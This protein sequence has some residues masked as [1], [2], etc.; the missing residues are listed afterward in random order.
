MKRQRGVAVITAI[1]VVALVASAASFMAWQQQLWVRQ[2]ENLNERAQ[3][4]VVA[5]TA[6]QWARA[7]LAQDAR[8]SAVDHL[9]E[10]WA[11]PLAPL[12]VEGGELAGGVADQQGLFNLNSLV[13]GGRTSASDLALFRRLLELL[14]LPPDLANAVVDWIDPDGE[15]S[16]PGGA[17]DMDYLGLEPP[18]RAANRAL[19]TVDGLARVKGFDAATLARLRPFVTALPQPTQ[20]NVNTAPAEVLAAALTGLALDEARALVTAR[21][22]QPFKDIADFR[23]RL[24]KTVTQVND[25][26]LGVGSHYFL[27]SGHARFGRAKV[28][29]EALL[30]RESTAWPK[31]VWQKNI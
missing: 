16:Y 11:Q 21:K 2:V 19:T 3:S 31:L 24:P 8:E 17:E 9:D 20:V 18:Y 5:L 26:L 7:A 10:G 27:V 15:V 12:P 22:G 23:A 25:T 30:E 1:L 29:Y 4:R 6:L 13:R 14:D 28:G